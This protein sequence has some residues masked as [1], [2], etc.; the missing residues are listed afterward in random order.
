MKKVGDGENQKLLIL[1]LTIMLLFCGCK[2]DADSNSQITDGDNESR[3]ADN[4]LTAV[5]EKN[6][7]EVIESD[8]NV[9]QSSL[10]NKAH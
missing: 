6:K 5:T 9:E 7:S 10:K 3:I 2:K 8:T 1:S 4:E